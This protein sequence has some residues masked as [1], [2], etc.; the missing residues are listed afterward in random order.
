MGYWMNQSNCNH[1]LSLVFKC[2]C[3]KALDPMEMDTLQKGHGYNNVHVGDDDVACI[4]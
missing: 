3:S 1:A 2:I 4:L